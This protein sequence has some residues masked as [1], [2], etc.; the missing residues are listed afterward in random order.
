MTLAPNRLPLLNG[1][2]F[3]ILF[4]I[5]AGISSCSSKKIT[6]TQRVEVVSI[7]M[8][9]T[10]KSTK[11]ED[12]LWRKP[13]AVDIDNNLNKT[14]L[15][16]S[17]TATYTKDNIYLPQ[18]TNRIRNLAVILPFHLNQI[19][20]GQYADDTTKQLNPE[21]KYAM[22]FYL[23][24]LMAKEKFA[25]SN[26]KANVY[27]LDDANDSLST[28]NLLYQKPF[29]NVDY[30]IGPL[31]GKNL[32]SIAD[33]AKTNKITMLSPLVN[34]MYIRDNAYYFNGIASPITQYNFIFEHIKKK[35][36]GKTIEVV[37]DGQDASDENIDIL[38]PLA[39]KHFR[40]NE[41]KYISIPMGADVSKALNSPDTTTDRIIL[42]YS[43]KDSYNKF[44]IGKLKQFKNHFEVF[45]SSCTRNT[46]ALVE[47][48]STNTV[49]TVSPYNTSNPNYAHF[50]AKF[51]EKYKK[52]PN[53]AVTIGFDL[54]MHLFYLMEKG[55]I[56]QDNTFNLSADFDNTQTKFQF[57][58]ILNK[59]EAIDFY[60]N[61]YLN[62]YKYSNGTFIP[63]IP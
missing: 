58:P 19:P 55:I 54:M 47:V 12:S 49:Y 53:D 10:E 30:I 5:I 15:L 29:P 33:Y 43:N 42:I 39:D 51:E 7:K 9:S 28:V 21:S 31:Y 32:K 13:E 36:L 37:Y 17:N 60:D 44:I 63:F 27:F 62:L 50:A 38:K 25:N 1:N 45:T 20:L 26:L 6:S 3:L 57:K 52:T 41:I 2:N 35:Y 22:D 48:K 61:T 46:K 14:Q 59:S 8:P 24:C 56:L 4:T 16:N 11:K 34:S 23:G 18:E 40:F